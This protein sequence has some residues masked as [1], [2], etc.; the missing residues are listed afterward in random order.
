MLPKRLDKI[1]RNILLTIIIVII[2]FNKRCLLPIG[3]NYNYC[4][5]AKIRAVI[6]R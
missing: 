4:T 5:L 2:M 6:E 3:Y 1:E